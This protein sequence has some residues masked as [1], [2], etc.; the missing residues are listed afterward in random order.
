MQ[1]QKSII[2]AL[3]ILRMLRVGTE[4]MMLFIFMQYIYFSKFITDIAIVNVNIVPN[5]I[6]DPYFILCYLFKEEKLG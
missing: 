3:L 2:S 6:M 4:R 5:M 1:K